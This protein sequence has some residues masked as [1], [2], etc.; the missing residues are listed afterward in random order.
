MWTGIGCFWTKMAAS[1]L[2]IVGPRY[3]VFTIPAPL[4]RTGRRVW[5][6]LSGRSP[7]S[8]MTLTGLHRLADR[9]PG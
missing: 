9:A 3:W 2:P 4:A 6:H 7:R 1:W 5:L 8:A